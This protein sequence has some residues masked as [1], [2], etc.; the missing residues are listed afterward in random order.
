[1]T[2]AV[3]Q[4]WCPPAFILKRRP[5]YLQ[6]AGALDTLS[7]WMNSTGC[8]NA[9]PPPSHTATCPATSITG[10]LLMSASA[11]LRW[12]PCSY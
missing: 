10:T 2:R 7:N 12:I 8:P 5:Q 9:P 6:M 11:S 3:V 1:M 4:W